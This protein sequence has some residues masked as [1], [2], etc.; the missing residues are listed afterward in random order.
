M[1]NA[2]L[3]LRGRYLALTAASLLVLATAGMAKDPPEK[4]Q[5][6]PIAA[7]P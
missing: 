7:T 5:A 3:A 6:A 1:T 4:A 2:F